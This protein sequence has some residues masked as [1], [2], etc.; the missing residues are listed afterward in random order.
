MLL[1]QLIR[2]KRLDTGISV[3]QLSEKARVSKSFIYTLEKGNN[4]FPYFY[5]LARVMVALEL[6]LKDL[7]GIYHG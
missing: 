4:H 1:S 5:N 6:D 3:K 7:N 2:Q